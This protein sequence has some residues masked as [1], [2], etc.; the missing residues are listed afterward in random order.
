M[1]HLKSTCKPSQLR[2]DKSQ[3]LLSFD[4]KDDGGNIVSWLFSKER[5]RLA[6]ARM[7]IRDKLPFSHV[8]DVRFRD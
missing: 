7:I 5:S 4:K 8:E 2:D 6:C 1:D 3:K